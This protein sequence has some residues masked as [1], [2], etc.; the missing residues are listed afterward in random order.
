MLVERERDAAAG[1]VKGSKGAG[2]RTMVGKTPWRTAPAILKTSPI[3]HTMTNW[4]ERASAEPDLQF[5]ISCGVKTM[6]N[7][8]WSVDVCWARDS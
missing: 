2:V 1:I 7:G 3:S 5:A 6:T 8:R 4:I